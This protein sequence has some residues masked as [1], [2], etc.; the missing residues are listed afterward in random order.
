MRREV[1]ELELGD[2]R[3]P[4]AAR[5][6]RDRVRVRDAR[7]P[8]HEVAPLECR[9]AV[10]GTIVGD[11]LALQPHRDRRAAGVLEAAVGEAHVGAVAPQQPRSGQTGARGADDQRVAAGE[12][13]TEV[14]GHCSLKVESESRASSA[15]TM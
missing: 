15:P 6:R 10:D 12:R 9:R 5:G 14:D 7:A 3:N 11:V 2:H 1:A 8:H 4:A 13:V